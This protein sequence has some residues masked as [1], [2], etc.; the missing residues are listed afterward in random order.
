MENQSMLNIGINLKLD[1]LK[2]PL[3]SILL[4]TELLQKSELTEGEKEY[5]FSIINKSCAQMKES[6]AEMCEYI[7][8]VYPPQSSHLVE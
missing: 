1:D 4:S 3:T 6:L 7:N 8:E 2:N 5:V